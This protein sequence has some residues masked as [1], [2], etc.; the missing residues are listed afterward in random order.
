MNA[1]TPF[2]Y[3]YAIG[4]VIFAIGLYFGWRGGYV[5]WDA[6]SKRRNL[7]AMLGGLGLIMALQAYL[8]FGAPLTPHTPVKGTPLEPKNVPHS[9]DYG[10]MIGYFLAILALGTWFGRHNKSTKDFFFG[11]QR[12]SWWFIT[13]SLVATVIGSYS[14]VK[15]SRVA[16]TY[17]ISSSQTYL[18]DWFWIP[19]FLFGWLPIIFFS[20]IVSIP[21]YFE[22]R[23]N[24]FARL[25]VTIML[26][27]YLIGYIGINLFTMGKALHHLIGWDIFTA[28]CI[29]ASISAVY[30][31]W[32]GQT[33][34]IVTDLFQGF[35]LILAGALIVGLGVSALGG[36]SEFWVSLIPEHRMAFPNFAS[37][38]SYSTVGIVWQDAVANTA[39]FYFLNQGVIMRFL[40]VKSVTE[41]KK[42]IIATVLILMPI[43]AIVVASGGWVGSAMQSAG[44]I[45]ADSDAGGIFFLVAKVLCIPGVFGLVMAALTAALMSTVDTLITAVAA[46]AVNDVWKQYITA[47]A[48]DQYYLKI[49]RYTSIAV[50]LIGVALVPLFMSFDSI[51]SAHGAFTAAVTPP[52]VV[53]LLL[54][55]LWP[56]YTSAAASATILGG[57]ALILLSIKFPELIDPL[58]HGIPTVKADGTV[59]EGAKAHK[60]MRAFFGLFVSFAIGVIVTPFSKPRKEEEI[61]GLTQVTSQSLARKQA[62]RDIDVYDELPK[63]PAAIIETKQA[64]PIDPETGSYVVRLNEAALEALVAKVGDRVLIADTRWW[65]GGLRSVHGIIAEELIEAD[66]TAI[67]L[68]PELRARVDA[69]RSGGVDLESVI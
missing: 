57:F 20:K 34:V 67:E 36:F 53:A 58:A 15:Y 52:L 1:L 45:P 25:N 49:A 44:L 63:T 65:F 41:G 17:G 24:R 61:E 37:D 64:T 32:G 35:M 60:F 38:P 23:F 28:S 8:Q 16:Y 18:N 51:Y 5:G 22:R 54:A 33:S 9:L 66:G 10:V 68:G 19:L 12:F 59:L 3:Q 27:I 13:M 69:S 4:G 39:V 62:G 11:G 7:L 42:A 40:S 43:A 56:R 26:L 47:D 2:L 31:T 46:I 21:E 29:V 55:V 50:A 6:P 30:V 14:F 48:P